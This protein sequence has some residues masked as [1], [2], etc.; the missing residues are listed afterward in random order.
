MSFQSFDPSKE[1][2]KKFRKSIFKA[3][4]WAAFA[5][6]NP[7][8]FQA[9]GEGLRPHLFPKWGAESQ[10][11]L[12]P[13]SGDVSEQVAEG[14]HALGILA[15]GRDEF[16]HQIEKYNPAYDS[17]MR[18]EHEEFKRSVVRVIK[19]TFPDEVTGDLARLNQEEEFDR[20]IRKSL[21]RLFGQRRIGFNPITYDISSSGIPKTFNLNFEIAKIDQAGEIHYSMWRK[22]VKRDV[23]IVGKNYTEV[24]G[25]VHTTSLQKVLGLY[26]GDVLINADT[27]AQQVGTQLEAAQDAIAWCKPNRELDENYTA[28][29]PVR[30]RGFPGEQEAREA[31]SL[32]VKS[33]HRIIG[34]SRIV[35]LSVSDL[36][37]E[38]KAHEVGHGYRHQEL[39]FLKPERSEDRAAREEAFAY[40]AELGYA[41]RFDNVLFD[42]LEAQYMDSDY[43]P[44]TRAKRTVWNLMIDCLLENPGRYGVDLVGSSYDSRRA[45]AIEAISKLF[46]DKDLRLELSKDVKDKLVADS[47]P[48][49]HRIV[50]DIDGEET[51]PIAISA[52]HLTTAGFS[53]RRIRRLRNLK[54]AF[55]QIDSLS[56][57]EDI[58]EKLH[59]LL[60][61]YSLIN[62]NSVAKKSEG[63]ALLIKEGGSKALPIAVSLCKSYYSLLPNPK[64]T[65]E[66]LLDAPIRSVS[67]FTAVLLEAGIS[68]RF[69]LPALFFNLDAQEDTPT[70]TPT[71]EQVDDLFTKICELSDTPDP[72]L[73]ALIPIYRVISHR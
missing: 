72:Y 44:H 67:E 18:A 29:P 54:K 24:D 14:A 48:T 21:P 10:R 9:I 13:K 36:L 25:S 22:S 6:L 51:I 55:S 42:L 65:A 30:L 38:V 41:P 46:N 40:A 49:F 26:S 8:A 45:S 27:T 12:G 3:S 32:Y 50:G 63:L 16:L 19:L 64:E 71:K 4:A 5:A 17:R 31:I 15:K 35:E 7:F 59:E 20:L 28:I 33:A 43:E 56:L 52:L 34:N 62:E 1:V 69:G 58:R 61:P 68:K 57:S 2:S 37:G 60:E 70:R 53:W 39:Y 47:I 73:R 66:D 23:L 11:H